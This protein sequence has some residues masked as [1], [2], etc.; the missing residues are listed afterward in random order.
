M[1]QETEVE[2]TARFLRHFVIGIIIVAIVVVL[3]IGIGLFW[4]FNNIISNPSL[5]QTPVPTPTP[6]SISTPAPTETPTATTTPSPTATAKLESIGLQY[7]DN[8]SDTNAP[9]LQITGYVVNVGTAKANNCTIHV[10][11]T[12]SGNVTTI[13]TSATI[14]SLDPE[15]SEP[16]DLQFPYT[17]QALVAYNSSLSWTN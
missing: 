9:F 1:A 13:D 4:A 5:T 17:G 16:I 14:P 6:Y 12:Q 11:A 15:A 7:T 3:I 2:K 10:T 8:R